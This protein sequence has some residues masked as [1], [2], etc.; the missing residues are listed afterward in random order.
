MVDSWVFVDGALP[1]SADTVTEA[2]RARIAEGALESV[3]ES[4]AGR[5][6]FVVSNTERALVMLLDRPGDPGEHATDPRADS[7]DWSDGYVLANGQEDEYPDAET[8]PL[9]EA[10]R[11]VR[12]ILTT[13]RPPSDASWTID[14]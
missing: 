14:R 1:A 7:A 8:V 3:L 12:H 5:T 6:L 9:A 2:L 13:G 11:I 4:S 10:L